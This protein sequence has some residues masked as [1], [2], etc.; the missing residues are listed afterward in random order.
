METAIRALGELDSVAERA[1]G[2][3][4][5]CPNPSE[6]FGIDSVDLYKYC[7]ENGKEPIDLTT[8]E[9][10]MFITEKRAGNKL[11]PLPYLDIV[12]D[13]RAISK[14]SRDKG[15][16]H[17]DLTVRELQQFILRRN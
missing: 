3:V 4:D 5:F 13:Y 2:Y 14:Y 9:R 11:D 15:V 1:G 12:Y 10:N 17:V 8:R 6:K 7:Q 16:A